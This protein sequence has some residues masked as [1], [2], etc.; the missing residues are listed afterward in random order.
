[1]G[2]GCKGGR[3]MP[4]CVTRQEFERRMR[5]LESEVEGEKVVTRHILEQTQRNGDDLG[6]MKADVR[7][8]AGETA[9]I[10]GVVTHQA[11]LLNVLTQDVGLMRLDTNE[12]RR[13]MGDL[14]QEMSGVH[15]DVGDLRQEMSG[16]HRDV[17]DLRQD[18][19]V[20]Q[21]S[22]NRLEQRLD[23]LEGNVD[24]MRANVDTMRTDIAAVRTDV[25][26][27]RAALAPPTL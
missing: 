14:R 25:A 10:K 2:N 23:G 9:L 13:D 16:V 3:G 6:V 26:A 11:G 19:G 1:M 15:R 21:I 24:T 5:E 4:G 18:V 8:L 20:M 22:L 12:M 7:R 27:I 17:G